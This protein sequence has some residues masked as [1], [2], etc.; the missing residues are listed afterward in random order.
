MNLKLSQRILLLLIALIVKSLM[1]YYFLHQNPALRYNNSLALSGGDTQQYLPPI[2]SLVEKGSYSPDNR[3]PGL[4][5]PYYLFRLMSSPI[6]AVNLLLFF[7]I[8]LGAISVLYLA[9]FAYDLF[10]NKYMFYAVYIAYLFS[11]YVSLFDIVLL[12]ESLCASA[13]I[14]YL[15]NFTRYLRT[16]K[17]SYLFFSGFFLTWAVFLRPVYIICFPLSLLILYMIFYRQKKAVFS[18]SAWLT[19]VSFLA[20]FAFTDAIWTVR[21]EMKYHKFFPLAM[22]VSNFMPQVDLALIDFVSTFG[23]DC[24]YWNPKAEINWFGLHKDRTDRLGFV[25]Y[26]KELP[27]NIYTSKFN[28]DSLVQIKKYVA[29]LESSTLDSSSSKIVLKKLVDKMNLYTLSIQEEKPFLYHI[30]SRAIV[31]NKFLFHSGTYNLLSKPAAKLNKFELCLKYFYSLL[32]LSVLFF[33]MAGIII[34]T[35]A[36]FKNSIFLFFALIAGYS[37]LIHPFLRFTEYRYLVPCYPMLL[38]SSV[39]MV[40]WLVLKVTG[41]TKV[42]LGNRYQK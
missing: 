4:G 22:P 1:A 13:L 25:E 16:D 33:G 7:Q 14:F 23:G 37:I 34:L 21:N 10:Q 28:R 2:D 12:T 20:V 6:I 17:L 18:K 32:Y 5:L 42:S 9:L 30:S 41:K 26:A 39:Y 3:M 29:L 38:V 24:V 8:I 19:L 40:N 35:I 31:L 11:T 27:I 36:G 15:Y